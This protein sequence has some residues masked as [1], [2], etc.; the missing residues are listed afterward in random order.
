MFDQTRRDALRTIA[1]GLMAGSLSVGSA[2]HVHN[3]AA[4]EKAATG[5]YKPKAFT[6]H[7]YLTLQKLADYII[8]KDEHSP[9]ATAAGAPAFIDLLASQNPE[10]RAIYTGGIA[11]LDWQLETHHRVNFLGASPEM[12]IGVLDLIAYRKNAS[13]E[14]G[15]GILFFDWARKMVVDSFYT[16]PAGVKD[17]GYMGNTAVAKFEVPKPALDYALSRSPV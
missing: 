3:M 12:Q 16:S 5:V 10:L 8:P 11:W 13:P 17:I 7:E 6:D 15:P 2:Q 14:T 1:G 9:G 4:E